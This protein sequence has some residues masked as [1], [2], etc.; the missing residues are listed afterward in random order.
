MIEE[1]VVHLHN[2][3]N[4]LFEKCHHEICSHMDGTE[5]KII[6]SEAT[7][8]QKHKHGIYSHRDEWISLL[9]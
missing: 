9:K 4:Q 8:T 3:I 7:Q 2:V 1:N 6:L 5:K